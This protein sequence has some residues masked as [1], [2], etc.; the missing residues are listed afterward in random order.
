MSH[1]IRLSL[2]LLVVEALADVAG[3]VDVSVRWT[4]RPFY[5]ASF[6]IPSEIYN[7]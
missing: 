6:Y 7:S 1:S 4:G 5:Q 3:R 2:H